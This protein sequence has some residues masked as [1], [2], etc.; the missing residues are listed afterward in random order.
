MSASRAFRRGVKA[1]FES[2]DLAKATESCNTPSAP[3]VGAECKSC[4]MRVILHCENCRV[5]ITGCLDTEYARFGQEQAWARATARW[6]ED[7]ARKRAEA[8][9]LWT[10]PR[11]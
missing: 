1:P 6:G 10:P 11:R 2:M 8:A 7:A 9:G 3:R 4:E 5:Q